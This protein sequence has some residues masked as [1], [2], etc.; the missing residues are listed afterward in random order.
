MF[1]LQ[2][3]SCLSFCTYRRNGYYTAWQRHG[4]S[5]LFVI[6]FLTYNHCKHG[7]CGAHLG[8]YANWRKWL[9]P[10]NINGRLTR[11]TC[12][13]RHVKSFNEQNEKTPR[14]KYADVEKH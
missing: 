2:R 8:G 7:L 6:L 4:Y 14:K 10:I 9:N 11:K 13:L 5:W 3:T 1:M 12:F